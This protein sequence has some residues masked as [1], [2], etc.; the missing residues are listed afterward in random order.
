MI[1]FYVFVGVLLL[2]VAAWITMEIWIWFHD[3]G[4][5]EVELGE[6]EAEELTRPL[7]NVHVLDERREQGPHGML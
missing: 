6:A 1:G 7:G 4:P 2:L 5:D 3:E